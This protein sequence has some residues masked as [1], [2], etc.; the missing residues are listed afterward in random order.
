MEIINIADI[1]NPT[2]GKT[3][4]EENREIKHKYMVGDLVEVIGW[5]EDCEFDGMRMYIVGCVRDCDATPLYNL[6][7]KN[8]D[9]YEYSDK[10]A[11]Y[12]FK[13]YTGFSE[14]SL[15][16]VKTVRAKS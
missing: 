12:N 6:G 7:S 5:G 8:M 2:T 15:K 1:T 9:L 11:F 13:S 3:Y 14:E 16:L 4:R 10:R